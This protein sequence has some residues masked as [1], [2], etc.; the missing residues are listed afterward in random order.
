LRPVSTWRTVTLWAVAPETITEGAFATRGVGR[1]AVGPERLGAG[2]FIAFG[3]RP[4]RAA[5]FVAIGL[6]TTRTIA[7]RPVAAW[8]IGERASRPVSGRPVAAGTVAKRLIAPRRTITLRAVASWTVA[9]GALAAEAGALFLG[10][11]AGADP[12]ALGI[13]DAIDAN[14]RTG[15]GPIGAGLFTWAAL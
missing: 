7:L 13:V 10:D 11:V 14:A 4:A 2:T 1:T 12:F 5:W 9:V 8:A 3:A 15:V 6:F